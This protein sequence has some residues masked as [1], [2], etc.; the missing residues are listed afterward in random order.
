[1][2]HRIQLQNTSILAK[3]SIHMDQIIREVVEI[4]LHPSNMNNR[5]DGILL[6]K[7]W[8]SSIHALKERK[9][10]LDKYIVCTSFHPSFAHGPPE[11]CSKIYLFF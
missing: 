3:K 5:E 11:A 9:Q 8:K 4:E 7:S 1:M 2:T 10:A 6:S